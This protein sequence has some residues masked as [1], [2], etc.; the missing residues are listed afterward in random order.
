[1]GKALRSESLYPKSKTEVASADEPKPQASGGGK[2]GSQ[3]KRKQN[4]AKDGQK[5]KNKQDVECFSCGK[6][7][8]YASNCRAKP[9]D[10]KCFNCGQMGYHKDKCPH[11]PKEKQMVKAYAL[12]AI[13]SSSNA[14]TATE[15]GKNVVI[16]VCFLFM[17]FLLEF[18]LIPELPVLL[19]LVTW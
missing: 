14:P 6:K 3:N 1:M 4:Q 9:A 15:K 2:G 11:P 16:Q 12:N 7:G 5:K 13:P 18:C 19:Y 8:H 17:M 10:R